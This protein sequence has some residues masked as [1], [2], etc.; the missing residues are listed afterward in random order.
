MMTEWISIYEKL[1]KR[2][3]D[4]VLTYHKD[5]SIRKDMYFD[6]YLQ[7]FYVSGGE[8]FKRPHSPVTHYILMKIPKPPKVNDD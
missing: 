3:Q 5:H 6:H 7:M 2:N 1:P 8:D 4:F